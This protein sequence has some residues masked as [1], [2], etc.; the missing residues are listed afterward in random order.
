MVPV[1]HAKESRLFELADLPSEYQGALAVDDS[2]AQIGTGRSTSFISG[3][4]RGSRPALR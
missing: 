2:E 3:G 1:R 4:P